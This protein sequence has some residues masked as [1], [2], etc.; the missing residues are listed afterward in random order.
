MSMKPFTLIHRVL[1]IFLPRSCVGCGKANEALCDA[2]REVFYKFGGQ[3]LFCG[4]RNK[5]SKICQ[6]CLSKSDFNRS[7]RSLAIKQVLWTGR[8]ESGLKEAIWQLKYKKRKELADPLAKMLVQKFD[9]II[10]SKNSEN[11]FVVP[12]PLHFKKEY[13]RGF[14]QSLLLAEKFSKATGISL[15]KN[16]LE[17]VKETKTHVEV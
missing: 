16:V 2:C 12:I 11:F 8:Y 4:F 15:A 3:C 13:E 1:D 14:N 7:R 6:T 9:E 10:G 17:K 5:T